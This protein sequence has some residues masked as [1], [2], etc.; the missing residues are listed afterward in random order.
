MTATVPPPP[1]PTF[2]QLSIRVS[3]PLT[4]TEED[5][6]MG[7]VGYVWRRHGGRARPDTYADWLSSFE[8]VV[9]L[10]AVLLPHWGPDT[11]VEFTDMLHNQLADGSPI[12]KDATRLIDPMPAGIMFTYG[13]LSV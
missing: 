12:R 13:W 11:A 8:V 2:R 1:G 3:R 6:L 7:H 10:P 9:S 5:Q 4:R